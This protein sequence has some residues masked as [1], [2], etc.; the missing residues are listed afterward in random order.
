MGGAVRGTL[1]ALACAAVL[2]GCTRHAGGSGTPVSSAGPVTGTTSTSPSCGGP[3]YADPWIA[4]QSPLADGD[5]L[6]VGGR[7][8]IDR[9]SAD[10]IAISGTPGAV[11]LAER[12]ADT[13]IRCGKVLATA[14]W[15]EVTA[16]T[17]GRVRLTVAGGPI[18]RLRVVAG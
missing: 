1:G 12:S 11:S 7:G 3:T 15:V 13:E 2:A 8:W 6:T 16:R 5:T 17:P 4:F 9:R 14:Y 10:A 18:L